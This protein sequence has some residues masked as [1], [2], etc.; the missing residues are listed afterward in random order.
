MGG[1]KRVRLCV[2]RGDTATYKSKCLLFVFESISFVFVMKLFFLPDLKLN[3]N[4]GG[5]L[6]ILIYP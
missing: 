1:Y 4:N 5:I 6:L 2:F 3:N